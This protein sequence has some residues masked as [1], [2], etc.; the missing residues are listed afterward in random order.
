V[1]RGSSESD[2]RVSSTGR[3]GTARAALGRGHT[4]GGAANVITVAPRVGGTGGPDRVENTA[5]LSASRGDHES[6][7]SGDSASGNPRRATGLGRDSTRK[8]CG[9]PRGATGAMP[10]RLR[11][12]T[13]RSPRFRSS[14]S[15]SRP[16]SSNATSHRAACLPRNILEIVGRNRCS[17]RC[18]R[19]ECRARQFE[20]V[21]AR[22]ADFPN[23]TFGYLRVNTTPLDVGIP[24]WVRAS[25]GL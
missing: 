16:G 13:T 15:F 23:R 14:A 6:G 3:E 22:R 7:S 9:P 17:T 19:L 20:I 18:S 8:L 1:T 4:R 24:R 2:R 10:C 5:N 21:P 12:L 25:N 11:N